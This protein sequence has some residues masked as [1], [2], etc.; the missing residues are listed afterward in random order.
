M[1]CV[2]LFRCVVNGKLY[3]GKTKHEFKDYVRGYQL[4]AISDEPTNR[5]F[6]KALRKY[7][8]DAFEWTILI[9]DE[10]DEFLCFMERRWIK[11]LGTKIPN[12]YNMTDGGDG[13]AGYSPPE[14]TRKKLSLALKGESYE[15]VYG[16]RAAEERKKRSGAKLGKKHSPEAKKKMSEAKKGRPAHNK[17]VPMPEH[18]RIYFD[19]TGTKWSE[20]QRVLYGLTIKL[21]SGKRLLKEGDMR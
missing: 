20:K 4:A 5:V 14:E 2:Y 17:G 12:G 19:R 21:R 1:G 8:F 10:E 9:E 7:G 15:A 13:M 18:Q 3:V 11:Q 16:D 6:I